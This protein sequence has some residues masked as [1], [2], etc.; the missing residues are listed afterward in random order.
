M[1]GG[2]ILVDLD[3]SSL[4]WD[5]FW[6]TVIY[7]AV[8]GISFSWGFLRLFQQKIKSGIALLATCVVST[9]LFIMY[10]YDTFA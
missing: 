2:C 3:L 10:A 4:T 8:A 6:L 9:V 1:K 7:L 5:Q